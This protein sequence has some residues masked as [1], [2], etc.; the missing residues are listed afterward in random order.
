[1]TGGA[2]SIA[3]E[4]GFFRSNCNHLLARVALSLC[5]LL[6][7]R[8]L[9]ALHPEGPSAV[10]EGA[11]SGVEPGLLAS[12]SLVYDGIALEAAGGPTP[13]IVMSE[14]LNAA[15][16]QRDA[17]HE[18]A[19]VVIDHPLSTLTD[20]EIDGRARQAAG[21]YVAV[22]LRRPASETAGP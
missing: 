20:A 11:I 8:R 13:V 15:E 22:W 6:I 7:S 14:F 1:M 16:V 17:L 2:I 19:S 12:R 9:P 5:C 4:L 21:L 18:L 3:A 10:A